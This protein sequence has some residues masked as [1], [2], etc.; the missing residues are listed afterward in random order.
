MKHNNVIKSVA[1][2]LK[3][4]SK[5][6]MVVIQRRS[7]VILFHSKGHQF[8]NKMLISTM[9]EYVVYQ[10]VQRK[11]KKSKHSRVNHSKRNSGKKALSFDVDTTITPLNYFSG[12]KVVSKYFFAPI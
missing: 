12:L 9:A 5:V 2:V 7:N 6:K 3:Y 1:N 10:N 4:M 8:K 11:V